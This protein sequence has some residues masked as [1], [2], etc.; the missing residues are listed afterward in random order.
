MSFKDLEANRENSSPKEEV[1]TAVSTEFTQSLSRIMA[2][3]NMLSNGLPIYQRLSEE[4][5]EQLRKFADASKNL[6]RA[7]EKALKEFRRT[8]S[9]P[10]SKQAILT[11]KWE[12]QLK[13]EKERNSRNCQELREKETTFANQS[14]SSMSQLDEID[15]ENS[16]LLSKQ[17]QRNREDDVNL[18]DIE[19]HEDVIRERDERI[20]AFQG[21]VGFVNSIMR[22]VAGLVSTQGEMLDNVDNELE[23]SRSRTKDALHQVQ[24]ASEYDRKTREKYCYLLLC[25]AVFV[26]LLFVSNFSYNTGNPTPAV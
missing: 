3:N 10:S 20:S 9:D 17:D 18:A 2:G 22:E 1:K 11:S 13:Q 12:R 8:H 23:S 7:A 26:F 24:K 15:E 14:A 25:V 4:K 19:W 21:R 6:F 16:A 5:R